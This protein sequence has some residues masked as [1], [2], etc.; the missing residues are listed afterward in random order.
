M[1]ILVLKAALNEN[2]KP[3]IFTGLGIVISIVLII[4]TIK[5]SYYLAFLSLP[6]T[7]IAVILLAITTRQISKSRSTLSSTEINL[8]DG[9]YTQ[10]Y[11]DST[12]VK[13]TFKLKNGKRQGPSHGYYEN[14]QLQFKI[15]YEKGYQIG[16]SILFDKSNKLVRKSEY[17]NDKYLNKCTEYYENGNVRMIQNKSKYTFYDENSILRCEIYI[18]SEIIT[19]DKYRDN[20][21]NC[22]YKWHWN[23][24][25]R[26]IYKPMGIWKEFNESGNLILELN[27]NNYD[28]QKHK[29]FN[30]L[31]TCYDSARTIT[32]SEYI[33]P[34]ELFI[35]RFATNFSYERLVDKN[36]KYRTAHSN[37]GGWQYN[38][39]N[40]TQVLSIEDVIKTNNAANNI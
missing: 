4:V 29:E 30:I 19:I 32:S 24:G 10:N 13:Q 39:F 9:R 33:N 2:K 34:Q 23:T 28:T 21:S 14:G 8:P 16:E 15:N 22:W 27:F 26:V 37:P 11:N 18:E 20:S 7:I 17:S 3:I 5:T 36:A 38:E 31:K 12:H 40:I 1:N 6:I 25:N 35:E